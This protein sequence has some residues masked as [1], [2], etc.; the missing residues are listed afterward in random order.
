MGAR[1]VEGT[2]LENRHTSNRIV[3]SNPTLSARRGLVQGLRMAWVLLFI[4]LSLTPAGGFSMALAGPSPIRL[5]I[6]NP[7]EE[8]LLGRLT[9]AALQ[10]EGFAVEVQSG[11]DPEVLRARALRGELDLFWDYTGRALIVSQRNPDR[12]VLR[13]SAR[14]YRVV[15]GADLE[16]GLVWGSMAP[17]NN[18][19]G[20]VMTS[21]LAQK[22]KIETVSDLAAGARKL[23]KKSRK[24]TVLGL[25]SIFKNRPDGFNALVAL[26]GF[27]FNSILASATPPGNLLDSL[28]TK[29]TQAV[30]GPTVDGR[31]KRFKLKVLKEDKPFFPAYN[32]APVWRKEALEANPAAA[33]VLDRLASKMDLAALNDLRFPIEIHGVDPVQAALDWFKSH[34]GPNK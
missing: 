32:P 15:S 12:A 7:I 19:Y 14:C 9:E 20:L 29:E 3:G 28:R 16:N 22:M 8:V 4:V 30:V 2:G 6:G 23:Y 13:D 11:L 33:S 25:E 21:A 10:A 31:I 27:E 1:V 24:K 5:G 34:W 18:S 17:G 26:Y